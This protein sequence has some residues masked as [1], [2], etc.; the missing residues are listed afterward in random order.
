MSRFSHG[1]SR[2]ARS[3]SPG[4]ATV[5]A[6]SP[7]TRASAIASPRTYVVFTSSSDRVIAASISRSVA[8]CSRRPLAVVPTPP[9]AVGLCAI[10]LLIESVIA[11]AVPSAISP[12]VPRPAAIV[13]RAADAV[14][15]ASEVHSPLTTLLIVERACDI[16][17][18]SEAASAAP[19]PIKA[20]SWPRISLA[21]ASCS[22]VGPESPPSA[23]E[24]PAPAA[25]L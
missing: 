20:I 2:T 13:V 14:S 5:A 18:G 9:A 16:R 10:I 25:A 11:S 21:A 6:A 22:A 8:T 17:S 1:V 23:D 12:L 7:R 19:E 15:S 24:L 3:E 4:D